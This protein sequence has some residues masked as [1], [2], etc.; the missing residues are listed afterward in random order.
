MPSVRDIAT[1]LE[2]WAP[3]ATQQSYDNV[4]LQVGDLEAEL[5][6]AVIAL[7]LTPAVVDEAIAVDANL[8]ITHHP[9]IFRP[10]R[11]ITTTDWNGSLILR[12]ARAGIALYCIHTNLDAARG[13]V[14]F[15]LAGQLGLHDVRFLRPIQEGLVKLITFVPA[16]HLEVVRLA[17]AEAGAGHIGRYDACAFVSKGTGYFRA[18]ADARPFIGEAG[19]QM[20]SAEEWRLETKVERWRIPGVLRALRAVHPYE[21][22]VYDVSPIEGSGAQTGMGTIGRLE[23]PTPLIE[24]LAEAAQSLSTDALRYT[25]DPRA[26]IENVAVCGGSGSDL[27]GDAL[28]ADADAFLTAD[29]TYHRFFDVLNPEGKPLMALID[30]MHYE[31]EACMESLLRDWL[32]ARFS[33]VEWLKTRHRTSPIQTFIV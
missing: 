31:T 20:E 32:Q 22:V 11:S 9:L 33:R 15:A 2:A 29:I 24:F 12:L 14:S 16:D 19:G 13:G 27:I 18:G 25:G 26:L 6:R 10:Q 7:D 4:G 1:A 17:L 28:R 3:K 8:I 21:E 5:T 23:N 30:A